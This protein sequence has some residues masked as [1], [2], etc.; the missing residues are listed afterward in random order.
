M[1]RLTLY[2][3]ISSIEEDLRRLAD[4][5]LPNQQKPRQILGEHLFLKLIERVDGDAS[6]SELTPTLEDLLAFSD[7]GDV[8]QLMRSYLSDFPSDLVDQLDNFSDDFVDLIKI[9]NR[10]M[11]ARPLEF[12]DLSR[13]NDLCEKLKSKSS[14]WVSLNEIIGRL[15]NEPELVLRLS[16]PFENDAIGPS[17]NLPMPDFDETGFIGR[18]VIVDNVIR[19]VLGVYPVVTLVGEGGLGKTSLALKVA[20]EILEKK[21]DEYDA[22]IFVS[23][24]TSQLTDSEIIRIRGSVNSS[25]GLFEVAAGALGGNAGNPLEDLISVL[26]QFR[27]LLIIDNLETVIDKN[28]NELL[29]RIPQGSKI[30]ITTRIRLGAYEFPVQL[31]PMSDAE[32]IQLLR[33]T[34]K[35]RSCSRLVQASN[36]VIGGFCTRMRNNPLHIKWFVSAVQAGKRPEEVLA[37]EKLFLQFCLSNVFSQVGENS[38]RL[39]R[40]LLALGGSYTVAELAFLTELDQSTLL[41]AIQELTRTNMFFATSAP[42]GASYETKYELSQLARAYLARFYPVSK[43]EQKQMLTVK[44]RLVSA[45]E[46]I[47]SEAQTNPLSASSIHCRTRSDWVIA[48]YLRESLSKIRIDKCDEALEIIETAKGLAPDFSE[49]YRVEA[50]AYARSGNLS[51]AYDCYEKALEWA[52]DSAIVYYLFGGFLLRD[53]H[54]TEKANEMFERAMQLCPERPEPMIDYARCCLFRRNF[55][56]AMSAIEKLEVGA[57]RNEHIDM[58]IADIHLQYF[59]RYA[60]SCFVN[61]EY[62]KCL[63]AL[64]GSREFYD[65]ISHP[66]RRMR[67][68]LAKLL[69]IVAQLKL[70]LGNDV[71]GCQRVDSFSSW[72]QGLLFKDSGQ[73]P[74]ASSSDSQYD[75]ALVNH[76][77]ICR[78]HGSGQFGFIRQDDGDEIYFRLSQVSDERLL[79]SFAVGVRV[80]FDT[81]FDWKG[82]LVAVNVKSEG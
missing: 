75:L 17:N 68:R 16:I 73:P 48:K 12:D 37:D 32:A 19:A 10:V 27:V 46:Q 65:S 80:K 29:S 63:E 4:K 22:L 55:V 40:T 43:E 21:P 42:T 71:D 50:W 53:M 72:I 23:A 82:R 76:G 64:E 81:K 15:S 9:R 79:T 54:D 74:L 13:T 45:G 2:A 5:Y 78:L 1:T 11:H 47:A 26:S 41:S 60:E 6:E 70:A 38:R 34:A 66:D 28:M 20:Y 31:D 59:T 69:Y 52:P 35:I 62:Y 7:L 61:H 25:I 58:K 33:V 30:L 44:R 56:D 67:D 18:R 36:K 49:V 14:Y 51:Q 24:K 3:L 57:I 39:V 8:Y 77:A